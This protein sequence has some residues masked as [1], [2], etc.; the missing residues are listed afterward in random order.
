MQ[1]KVIQVGSPITL[2]DNIPAVITGILINDKCRVT[3][4]CIWWDDQI[5]KCEWLEEFEVTRTDKI[6]DM[7]VGF[8]Q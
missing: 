2:A 6:Q 8:H 7:T 4:Q 5:R 1:I 3:Y